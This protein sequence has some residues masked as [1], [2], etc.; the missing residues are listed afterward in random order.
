MKELFYIVLF[1]YW[2]SIKIYD[3]IKIKAFEIRRRK[4]EKKNML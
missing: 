2:R 1:F 4:N 3:I